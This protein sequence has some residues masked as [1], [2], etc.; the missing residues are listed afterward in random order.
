MSTIIFLLNEHVLV[1]MGIGGT[2][3]GANPFKTLKKSWSVM[4]VE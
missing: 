3:R 4:R 1:I 2:R